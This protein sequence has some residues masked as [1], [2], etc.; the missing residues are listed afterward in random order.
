MKVISGCIESVTKGNDLFHQT[1]DAAD[2]SSF[3][4]SMTKMEVTFISRTMKI[5]LYY[6]RQYGDSRP[7]LR[8]VHDE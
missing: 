7:Y 5:T 8:Q 6:H 4:D 1:Y 3:I 2:L